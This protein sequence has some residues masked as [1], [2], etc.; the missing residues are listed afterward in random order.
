MAV[1]PRDFLI[2]AAT[3]A[4]QIEGAAFD[5]GRGRSIWD[6]FSHTPG[7]TQNGDT[8]DVACDH[9][10]RFRDD[11]SLMRSMGL[12]AYRFSIAWPR[13]FPDGG[14]A[15]GGGSFARRGNQAGFDFY[16]RLVEGLLEAGIQPFATLY[17]WDLPAALQA[18]GGWANRDT[19]E[20]FGEYAHTVFRR[21]GHLIPHFITLNEP[22][23]VTIMGHVLG[24]HAPG[25]RNLEAAVA[26]SHNLLLAH[27]KAVQAFRSENLQHAQIGIAN[28]L[29]YVRPKTNQPADT[30]AAAR[31]DDVTNRWF[32]DPIFRGT[33]PATLRHF[34]IDALVQP[35]DAA[36]ISQPIDFLGVNYYRSSVVE[37]NPADKLL[38]ATI[39]EPG[40]ARTA[41]DWGVDAD[42]LFELLRDLRDNTTPIPLYIT[43]N[44]A[45]YDDVL[46]NGAVHDNARIDYLEQHLECVLR[47]RSVGVDVRGYFAWSL[48]DNFEWAFGYAKRFGLI[49]VDYASQ[50][51][52]QKDSAKWLQQVA[53][54]RHT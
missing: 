44:G 18:H 29:T 24:E 5:D 32:L 46:V 3:A 38:G 49:Y 17:H 16:E 30:E 20:H 36:L 52:I 31:V 27:G 39:H 21:L 6:D 14:R 19:A 51:R 12:D 13:L 10:H 9:Y 33:Y 35:G 45:A 41:M 37:A 43:E 50:Q 26:A 34:G 15:V 25:L 53:E 2:G 47:A 48:L 4:Y 11:I 8:G 7:N 23:T 42:G 28:I 40:H 1:I 22:G 54:A